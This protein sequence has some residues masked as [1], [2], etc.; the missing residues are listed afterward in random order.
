M[1][2]LKN[3][4]TKIITKTLTP[5]RIAKI[6]HQIMMSII[7][8]GVD[9]KLLRFERAVEIVPGGPGEPSSDRDTENIVVSLFYIR[10]SE[11]DDSGNETG[12]FR[13]VIHTLPE[14]AEIV[15]KNIPIPGIDINSYLKPAFGAM[16]ALI[17]TS[18]TYYLV[19]KIAN[20][21]GTE[22]GIAKI[23]K[24]V[25]VF[26]S[27]EGNWTAERHEQVQGWTLSE[28]LPGFVLSAQQSGALAGILPQ[29]E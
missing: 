22:I 1:N 2:V 17:P 9:E 18:E 14:I 7:G 10:Q 5:E 15:S 23:R 26:Q 12:K 24:Y 3:L 19:G 29:A 25:D 13:R 28:V 4:Q 6:G 27:D 8:D 20:G 21:N 16:Q 11:I